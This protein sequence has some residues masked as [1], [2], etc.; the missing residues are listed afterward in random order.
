MQKT[1]GWEKQSAVRCA[2]RFARKGVRFHPHTP[3]T[4]TSSDDPS[5]GYKKQHFG[6][7]KKWWRQV[8]PEE[9]FYSPVV[10]PSPTQLW[11]PGREEAL[12]KP[13][14]GDQLPATKRIWALLPTGNPIWGKPGEKIR[15][16]K[17]KWLP[18]RSKDRGL[19]TAASSISLDT[20]RLWKY[21]LKCSGALKG[22]REGA[23]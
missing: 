23:V 10:S 16:I 17:Y 2:V 7:E 3:S 9:R 14:A 1:K 6:K 15:C 21:I 11:V 13:Q 19:E 5:W 18:S 12:M 8:S 4:L 22:A 20:K